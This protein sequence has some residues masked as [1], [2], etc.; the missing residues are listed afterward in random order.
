MKTNEK[1][2]ELIQ[3]LVASIYQWNVADLLNLNSLKMGMF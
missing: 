1:M 3:K 2:L